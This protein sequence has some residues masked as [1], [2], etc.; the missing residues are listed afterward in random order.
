MI[1]KRWMLWWTRK[2]YIHPTAMVQTRAIGEDSRIWA[3]CNIGRDVVIGRE[4][5]ICDRCFLEDGVRLGDRVTLKTGI[6]LWRGVTVEDDV[7]IGPGVQFCN[8]LFPRSKNYVEAVPTLL[9]QGCSLGAGAV[10]L[11][12]VTIGTYA[13][14]G[15]GA[16]VTRSVPD[17]AVVVGNPARVVRMLS[18]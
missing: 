3:F 15:A 9:R 5:N 17:R 14:V 8:D 18:A 13:M 7:F 12:G 4:A 10:I 6:S 16:V 11:P 2:V 1:V